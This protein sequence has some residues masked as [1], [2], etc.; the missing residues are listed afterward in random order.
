MSIGCATVGEMKEGPS[1]SVTRSLIPSHRTPSRLMWATSRPDVVLNRRAQG[2]RPQHQLQR[3]AG[4]LVHADSPKTASITA[5]GHLRRHGDGLRH[6]PHDRV[7]KRGADHPWP[8][9]ARDMATGTRLQSQGLLRS[10]AGRPL[11]PNSVRRPALRHR[12]PRAT[13]DPQAFR[14]AA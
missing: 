5:T 11:P 6:C 3:R 8:K 14:R 10:S 1:G 13:H 2:L 4:H 9:H 12:G 7:P